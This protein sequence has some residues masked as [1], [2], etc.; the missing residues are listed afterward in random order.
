MSLNTIA[1]VSPNAIANASLNADRSS[2][3]ELEA[4]HEKPHEKSESPSTY[5]CLVECSK[6]FSELHGQELVWK[7]QYQRGM[8][9]ANFLG[10]FILYKM[11]IAMRVCIIMCQLRRECWIVYDFAVSPGSQRVLTSQKVLDCIWFCSE[12]WVAHK[13]CKILCQ[14]VNY[15]CA[16]EGQS[17]Y[18]LIFEHSV[19]ASRWGIGR[20]LDSEACWECLL[21]KNV[22]CSVQK[23]VENACSLRMLDWKL[24]SNTRFRSSL[25][26]LA[27]YKC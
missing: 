22:E 5:R 8:T 4:L 10:C 16:Q 14:S 15:V 13:L 19:E 12:S 21:A 11:M 7:R 24:R 2:I 26:M 27:C 25:R 3:R 20:M 9:P 17:L 1:N 18:F 6:P 23:L